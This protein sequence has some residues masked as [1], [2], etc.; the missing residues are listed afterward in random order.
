[1]INKGGKVGEEIKLQICLSP[2][3]TF[4]LYLPLILTFYIF[5]NTFLIRFRGE[6]DFMSYLGKK[7]KGKRMGKDY[8]GFAGLMRMHELDYNVTFTSG[9]IK[10]KKMGWR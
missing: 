5:K 6:C 1:M 9:A 7:M 8:T 2:D 10:V 3:N 4:F